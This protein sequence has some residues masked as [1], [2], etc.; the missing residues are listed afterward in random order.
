[1][2][3]QRNGDATGWPM[4]PP[5]NTPAGRHSNAYRRI[6]EAWLAGQREYWITYG[7]SV[8]RVE[9]IGMAMDGWLQLASGEW[10][11]V[12]HLATS[13]LAARR[14]FSKPKQSQKRDST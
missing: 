1:M 11:P 5:R 3:S 2:V 4:T 13:M 8:R 14:Q 7:A 10:M 9:A 12:Q 6:R